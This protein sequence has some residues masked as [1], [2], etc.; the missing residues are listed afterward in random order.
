MITE[1]ND[2][3]STHDME[4]LPTM[5]MADLRRFRNRLN[6]V[7]LGLSYC[8]RMAQGHLDIL[9]AEVQRR[10]GSTAGGSDR[11]DGAEDGGLLSRL[12]DLLAQHSRG[13]GEAHLVIDAEIPAFAQDLVA[14]LDRQ[15]GRAATD[16]ETVDSVTISAIS[17]QISEFER[18]VS[19]KRHEVHRII[20]E[21]QEQIIERYRTG[22]V[23]V[24]ELLG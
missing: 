10:E 12:P 13:E 11:G 17:D 18:S 2:L 6:E 22:V 23:T 7:E 24:D 14:D 16:L 15:I 8:R 1:L 5:D 9:M 19:A 3:L 4:S 21:V 20:D